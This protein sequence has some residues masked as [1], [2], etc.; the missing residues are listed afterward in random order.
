ML[1]SVGRSVAAGVKEKLSTAKAAKSSRVVS[2]SS[3]PAS[4][5]TIKRGSL[6]CFC[7]EDDE[8]ETVEGDE[9]LGFGERVVFGP[10]PTE[11]EA[12]EAVNSIQQ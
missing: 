2:V 12:E 7:D 6:S 11:E 1:R 5:T 10:P 9:G 8:W 3:P 4:P